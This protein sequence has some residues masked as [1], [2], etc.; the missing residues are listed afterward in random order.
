MATNPNYLSLYGAVNK[1]AQPIDFTTSPLLQD[2]P[3]EQIVWVRL[4][5][6][7]NASGTLVSAFELMIQSADGLAAQV[8]YL[9]TYTGFATIMNFMGGLI[10]NATV[11]PF[12]NYVNLISM[13]YAT[14]INPTGTTFLAQGIL[15][16]TNFV[17]GNT[18]RR[19][20]ASTNS[21]FIKVKFSN[22]YKADVWEV[23]GNQTTSGSYSLFYTA[24]A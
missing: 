3:I 14:L 24:S 5:Y 6:I 11:V 9:Y 20:Q 23:D 2:C 12:V 1:N 18:G 16:N 7:T 4:G 13:N 21:T 19:Y 8:V 22:H 17:T 10:A 15:I